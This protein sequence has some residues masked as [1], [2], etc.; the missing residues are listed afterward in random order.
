MNV[1]ILVSVSCYALSI[2]FIFL[3]SFIFCIYILANSNSHLTTHQFSILNSLNSNLTSMLALSSKLI[4]ITFIR[5]SVHV[6]KVK[7]KERVTVVELL[8]LVPLKLRE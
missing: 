1:D 5:V 2:L 3:Y 4:M 7:M 6:H 8:C